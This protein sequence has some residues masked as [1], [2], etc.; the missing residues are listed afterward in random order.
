[1]TQDGD[2][3]LDSAADAK[4]W[5]IQ[6][7]YCIKIWICP[8]KHISK[9][10]QVVILH[11]LKLQSGNC[12][13]VNVSVMVPVAWKQCGKSFIKEQWWG[14]TFTVCVYTLEKGQTSQVQK[15]IGY[16]AIYTMLLITET[17]KCGCGYIYC[18]VIVVNFHGMIC[19]TQEQYTEI[20]VNRNGGDVE[21]NPKWC[22]ARL[23]YTSQL[24]MFSLATL[25]CT[26]TV[27]IPQT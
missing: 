3:G 18:Q 24:L 27:H 1:M 7:L 17:N 16:V 11:H 26:C 9:S 19:T 21:E 12:L 6:L 8:A 5:I 4:S 14:E 23:L 20:N 25:V 15:A 13:F 10:S 22:K 2:W